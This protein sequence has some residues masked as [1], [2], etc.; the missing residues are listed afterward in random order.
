MLLL[1]RRN[2][3]I[4]FQ[5][6]L[7]KVHAHLPLRYVYTFQIRFGERHVDLLAR[8]VCQNQQRRFAGSEL[9]VFDAPDFTAVIE[10]RYSRSGR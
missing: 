2:R 8:A 6:A 3:G 7:G 9:N 10:N 4:D 1:F 5:H